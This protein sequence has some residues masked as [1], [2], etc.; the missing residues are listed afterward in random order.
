MKWPA[1]RFPGKAVDRTGKPKR[2]EDS[3]RSRSKTGMC[4]DLFETVTA[5]AVPSV[6]HA[7]TLTRVEDE[8]LLVVVCGL[9]NGLCRGEI[10]HERLTG[11]LLAA[12]PKPR[13]RPRPPPWC[14]SPAQRGRGGGGLD[15]RS[16]HTNVVSEVNG[17]HDFDGQIGEHLADNLSAVTTDE[18]SILGA[19]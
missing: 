10:W 13:V 14:S 5:R 2:G 6:H 12:H 1:A 3:P 9:Y 7:S 11:F 8:K 17:A 16:R 19:R 4:M 18:V 15:T